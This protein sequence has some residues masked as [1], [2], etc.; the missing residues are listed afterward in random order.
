MC[1][2]DVECV[3]PSIKQRKSSPR[4]VRRAVC[5]V[6]SLGRNLALLR[7]P[8]KTCHALFRWERRGTHQK[9]GY[10]SRLLEETFA[11]KNTMEKLLEPLIWH[12]TK[13]LGNALYISAVVCVCFVS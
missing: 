1:I 12:D 3:Y 5:T 4:C 7:G 9:M 6:C 11:I 2:H 10:S 8:D 13:A